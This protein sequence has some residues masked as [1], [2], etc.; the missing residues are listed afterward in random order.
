[1][2]G[3]AIGGNDPQYT[4]QIYPFVEAP[5]YGRPELARA[6]EIRMWKWRDTR[7]L[8]TTLWVAMWFSII[9]GLCF[10]L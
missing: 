4:V 2:E 1:M 9:C 5:Y 8:K 7:T 3:L 10:A 6:D